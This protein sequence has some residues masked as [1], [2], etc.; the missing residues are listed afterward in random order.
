M[1]KILI[2]GMTENAGGVESVIMNYY[3]KLD[4]NKNKID[5]LCNTDKIAYES[6]IN[7]TG[8][9]IY[10]ITARSKNYK[11]Y[12]KE[13]KEFYI[14]H[15]NEYDTIWIN[16]CSLANMD[17]LKMAKKYKIKYR[18]IHS[19]NTE[20]MDSKLRGILHRIN[21]VFVK[22]YATDF[23]ACSEEAGRWFYN[24]KIMNSDRYLEVN[25]AIDLEKYKY[26]N[27]IRNEYRSNLELNNNFVVG[28][29]GRLHFQKNQLF[30]IDIFHEISKKIHN[31]KLLIVGQGEDESKLRKKVKTLGIEEKVIFLGIRN[32]VP[33]LLQAMDAFVFP[34]VFEGLGLALVEAQAVGLPTFASE[35]VIPRIVKMSKKF[36]FISLDKTAQEWA[37]IIVS[38]TQRKREQNEENIIANIQ[39][40]GY[41]I[42]FE[43]KKLEKYFQRN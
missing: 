37:E 36:H 18:I 42:N 31:A 14:N 5:F 43:V 8:G 35:K 11:K 29:V 3:R 1:N 20:N 19:H 6:E 17:Y 25:N 13:L 2:F 26:N 30:L 15:A 32:D 16:L 40:N 4:K 24:K 21:K 28:N 27:N 41:D 38:E 23:W 22:N 39:K 34:S 7:E 12:K 33:N 10:K 9:K